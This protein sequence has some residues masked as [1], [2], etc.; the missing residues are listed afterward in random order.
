MSYTTNSKHTREA[1]EKHILDHYDERGVAGLV[2]D[3]RAVARGSY[4][5]QAG[6]DLVEGGNF[7]ISYHDQREFLNSLDLNKKSGRNFS[8]D[9]VFKLYTE[10]LARQIVKL[11]D[12]YMY[13]PADAGED[14]AI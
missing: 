2:E 1:V 14:E 4:G 13:T 3:F 7:T 12:N 10:L 6:R 11:H 5:M 9:Q 8:D